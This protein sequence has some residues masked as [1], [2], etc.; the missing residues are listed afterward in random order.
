M[1]PEQFLDGMAQVP[2]F[3]GVKFTD[4]NFFFFQQLV[5]LADETDL[6]LDGAIERV[7]SS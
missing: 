6:F 1:T 5:D 7:A 3:A 4:T 2:H